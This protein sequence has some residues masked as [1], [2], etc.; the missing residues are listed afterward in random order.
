MSELKSPAWWR[1]HHKHVKR[2]NL[3][4]DDL[5]IEL[6][7]QENAHI[8]CEIGVNWIPF[9]NDK[10]FYL[11][12]AKS[13]PKQKRHKWSESPY[14]V[15]IIKFMSLRQESRSKSVSGYKKLHSNELFNYIGFRSSAKFH[16][17]KT[18]P[19]QTMNS[20]KMRYT[21]ERNDLSRQHIHFVA[22][23]M[24]NAVMSRYVFSS[25]IFMNYRAWKKFQIH[26]CRSN[27]PFQWNFRDFCQSFKII[28]TKFQDCYINILSF[29]IFKCKTHSW[30]NFLYISN[31]TQW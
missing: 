8:A 16:I 17:K 9:Q 15:I 5:R 24:L 31:Y 6:L 30:Y 4:T 12:F 13:I 19:I 1:Y 27:T 7:P 22:L 3:E 14:G 26:I 25:Q 29:A 28:I 11:H 23:S 20:W 21:L 2:N 10:N 18:Y